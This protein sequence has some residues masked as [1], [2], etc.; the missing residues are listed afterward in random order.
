[1]SK[2]EIPQKSIIALACSPSKGRN[3]DA[4]LDAFIEG[5]ETATT[6]PVSKVYLNDIQ[7][8]HF[9]FENGVGPNSDEKEFSTLCEKITQ[10]HGLIIATPTYNFSV[11]GQLKNFIDRIRFFALDFKKINKYK[12]PTGKLT[13]LHTYYLVSGGTPRWAQ[14]LLF[15]AFPAFWLRSVFLYYGSQC[16]GAF[17]SGDVATFNNEKILAACK[18]KGEKYGRDLEKEKCHSVPER[19]FWRPPQYN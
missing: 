17:Y 15:F 13:Y 4:M 8:A 16:M 10:A 1:M 12:Q 2:A 3:S 19:I 18:K 5:I 6:I 9:T 7:I 11:P 14:C